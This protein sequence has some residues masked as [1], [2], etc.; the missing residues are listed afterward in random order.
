MDLTA[1]ILGATGTRA[2]ANLEG[3]NLVPLLRDGAGANA[4]AARERPLF[5]RIDVPVRQQRA[6][7]R[8]QWKLLLDG[9]DVLLFDLSK[10]IGER[11]DVA[12]AQPT[13]VAELL[14]LLDAWERDVDRES[15]RGR[16][17]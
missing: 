4:R 8:G 13:I 2:P 10:D 1:T 6:V 14:R 9:D 17:R 5:W 3:R 12:H 7:R 15:G 16:G 11:Q